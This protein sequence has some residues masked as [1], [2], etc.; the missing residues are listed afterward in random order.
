[1]LG[2][3]HARD[4]L[5]LEEVV[6]SPQAKVSFRGRKLWAESDPVAHLRDFD[7]APVKLRDDVIFRGL[8]IYVHDPQNDFSKQIGVFRPGAYDTLLGLSYPYGE[9]NVLSPF[10]VRMYLFVDDIEQAVEFYCET[11]KLFKVIHD[12]GSDLLRRLVLASCDP[13]V[14]FCLAIRLV[15]ITDVQPQRSPGLEELPIIVLPVKD[16]RRE[17]ERLQRVDVSFAAPADR[18]A[19][20]LSSDDDRSVWKS[21]MPCRGIPR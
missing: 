2:T 13:A 20:R 3:R 15:M 8:G 18:V 12:S 14:R 4:S 7:D 1:M 17:Y 10:G 21:H 6:F 16:C 11:T 9:P 5:Q 19:L